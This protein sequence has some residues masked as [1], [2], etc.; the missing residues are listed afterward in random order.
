[1]LFICAGVTLGIIFGVL[2]GLGSVTALAVLVPVTFY[3]SPLAAIAFLVGINK[4][5]TSGGAIPAILINAPGTP[6]AAASALDGYPLAQQGK[7]EKAMKTALYSSVCGDTFSDIALILLA[8]PIAAVAL[9]FGPVEFTAI[10]LFSFTMI[11]ALAGKSLIK[12]IMAAALGVFLSTIGLDPVDSTERLTFGM[13]ELFDGIS[14]LPFAIGT[15]AL[16]SVVSQLFDLKHEE[17]DVTQ[18]LRS[19]A[20]YKEDNRLGF[21]EFWGTWKTLLRSAFIGTGIGMLPGLGVTLAAFLGY[22]A[23]KRG[24]KFEHEFGTGRLEGIQAT[25]AANSAVVGANLIPTIALGIPGN[26]AAAVLIGAFIIHGVVPGPLMIR[27]HGELVYSI[28]ASMLMANVA[29]LVIGRIGIRIWVQFVRIPKYIVL[30]TVVLLCIIGV[31]IP[32]NS[33]FDVGLLFVFAGLGYV[34]RKGGFSIVCLVIGFLLGENFE[35]SLR[36]A[37]LMNNSDLTVLFT[38]PI[39]LVFILLTIYFTWHFGFK[40]NKR[41]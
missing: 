21:L 36:Q 12:G 29:H 17:N 23:A 16:S 5:G 18:A 25:E 20:E 27:E 33:M 8:A 34:M 14:L 38:S 13:I 7:A 37:V 28:F 10:I 9:K 2:P 3:F 26:V 24:S 4:G 35:I 41:I 15:L 31:Y 40:S 11:A 32:S 6:E 22:G 39:A 1:M 30:P 19:A